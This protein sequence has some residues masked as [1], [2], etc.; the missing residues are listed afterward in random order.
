MS[1]YETYIHYGRLLVILQFIFI[2]V[3][4]Y[5]LS[6]V[7]VDGVIWF[8]DTDDLRILSDIIIYIIGPLIMSVPFFFWTYGR[9]YQIGD[10]YET[11][12]HEVWRL[13]T[14]VKAFYGFNFIVGIIFLFPII[15]PIV[16]LF[17]GYFI[18]IYLFKWREEGK[19]VSTQRKTILFTLLYLPLPLLVIM[20]FYFGYDWFGEQTGIL[21]FFIKLMNI[22][23][24]QL[25][26]IY[27]S[28]LILADSATI[29]GI[30]YLVYEGAQQVDHTVKV[31]GPLITLITAALFLFLEFIYLV[32]PKDVFP[33]E[34][35][36]ELFHIGAVI[37]GVLMLIVRYWKGLTTSRD[38]SII[39]WLSLVFFQA[40]NFI[41][42]DLEVISR[43][44]AIFMAF[45]IFF[46]LFWIAYRHSGRR[47]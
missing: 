22:W 15:T 2:P 16:S 43:S 12:G 1:D 9:R 26:V 8:L 47:Y 32:I 34:A 10:A 33:T 25:D 14:T 3:Y 23:N 31:P 27:T 28:A 42:G 17:G 24:S 7:F 39:G 45:G 18:A 37:L 21:G 30:L 5:L 46:F 41:S 36:L 20:G 40:V 11:F 44:T 35:L 29:G 13:P 4:F 6:F 38:T 19:L